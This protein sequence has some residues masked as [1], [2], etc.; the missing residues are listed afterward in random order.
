MIR[1][2]A[3]RIAGLILVILIVSFITFFMLY[4]LPGGPFDQLNQPLSPAALENIRAKYQLDKPFYVVWANYIAN[5]ARGDFGTSYVAEGTPIVQIFQEQWG[6]SLALGGMALAWSVPLGI[7][8]GVVAALKRN[9]LFD[10][11]ARFFAIIGTT[12]P[13]FALAVFLIYVFAVVLQILPTGGWE[14]EEPRTFVLPVLI[15]GLL[16]F[17]AVMRYTRNGMLEALSQDYI[18]VAKA[19]GLT[20]NVVV[21]KHA[22][23]NVLIPIITVLA[24][25]IPNA[26]TGSAIL[27]PMFRINGVGK[28]FID[29]L[30]SRDYPMVLA[31]V[32]I[33]AVLWGI[34]F[35]IADIAYSLADP[36]IRL[37][38]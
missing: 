33:V 17:G 30:A 29:S 16:P 8:L 37:G 28:L 21:F 9:R 6:A 38:K 11:L 18:R 34:S 32:L 20:G 5:A 10:Y 12:V 25:M 19:K 23:R 36:R 2:F 3:A 7:L 15:F 27:E 1:Y 4:Q 26:L 24:P 22:L 13:N 14:R 31:T 35:L